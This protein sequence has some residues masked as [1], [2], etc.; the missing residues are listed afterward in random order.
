MTFE[1]IGSRIDVGGANRHGRGSTASATTTARRPSARSS[2]TP[3]RSRSWPT[4][5][6]GSSSFASRARRSASRRCSSCPPASSTRTARS[7]STRRSASWPRRSARARAPGSHL[8]SFYTSPGFADEECH[9]YLATDLFD[10][11]AEADEDERIEIVEVPLADL[12]R[13]IRGMPRRED[14]RRPALVSR[15]RRADPRLA[16]ARDGR[17]APNPIGRWPP[18]RSPCRAALRAPRARLPRLPRVRARPVPQHARGVPRRPAS[19]SGASSRSSDLSA[20]DASAGDVGDFLTGLATGDDEHRRASPATIHRKSACLRSFYR[21]LRREGLRDSDPTATLSA[22]RRSRKLPQVLTRGEVERLLVAAARHRPARAA[23]PRAAGAD[24]RVRAARLGGDRAG[25]GDVDLEERVLRAR[26]KG[27]KERVVPIGQAARAGAAR[28]PRARPARA[29]QGPPRAAPVREL[30]RRPAD[31]PGPLQDRP[32]P[33]HDR[34]ARGPDEPAHAAPHVRHAPARGRLRPALGPGDARPRRRLD[35]PALHPPVE[36]AAQGRVLQGAPAGERAVLRR[37]AQ[38][39]R[40]AGPVPELPEVETIRRQLA[41]A[42]EGRRARAR[43][44]ARPAL[45]RPR[46][47]GGH[48]GRAA[49]PPDRARSA[50][51][52]ST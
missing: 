43:R 2:T 38:R 44:G 8:T 41:P 12:D 4:T 32:P 49:R 3:A 27:S 35:H 46:A 37:P 34:R 16:A 21:H 40:A 22:P 29:G 30:P 25:A 14:A 51:A 13:V 33:R 52:A 9:L 47:P 26:G 18:S 31:A 39:V 48:R 15:V 36:R 1:R 20:L 6:S 11:S 28:L 50:G 17:R 7:R 23:R 45:V 10:E 24:V 19:S 5:A 42:L